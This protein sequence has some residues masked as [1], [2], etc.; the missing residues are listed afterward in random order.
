MFNRRKKTAEMIV[1]VSLGVVRLRLE[2]DE[3]VAKVEKLEEENQ[4]LKEQN[5]KLLDA[6]GK[7]S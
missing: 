3:A 2:R 6:I 7:Q 1:E 5:L 4:F